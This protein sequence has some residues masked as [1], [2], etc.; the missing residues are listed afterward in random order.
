VIGR[1]RLLPLAADA[2]LTLLH[3]VSANLPVRDRR[4]AEGD[5]RRALQAEAEILARTLPKGATVRCVV[6]VGA[7][8]T[9]IVAWAKSVKAELIVMGR[10]GGRVFRDDFIGSTAERVVRRGQVPVLVVRLPPRVPY[11]RPAVALDLDEAAAAAIASLLRLLPTPRPAVAVIHALDPPYH[12]LIYPSLSRD[13]A[14]EYRGHYRQKALEDVARL[15]ASALAHTGATPDDAPR[16]KTQVRFGSPRS[17]IQTVVKSAHTDLLALGTR[18][19]SG[20]TH[21]FL[22]TVAGDVLRAVSCDVLV[23]PPRRGLVGSTRVA[24]H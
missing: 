6:E 22:G 14:H 4:R 21:A 23:V 8:A 20:I 12:G 7:P 11:R 13:D 10:G 2:R 16:W 24:R 1:A 19:R 18:G 15:L 5:A 9:V 17:L 3:V